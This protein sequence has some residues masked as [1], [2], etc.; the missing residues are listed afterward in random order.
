M[1]PT[2]Q[3]A[4]PGV[5]DWT[6]PITVRGCELAAIIAEAQAQ[7]FNCHRMTVIDMAVYRLMFWKLPTATVNKRVLPARLGTGDQPPFLPVA[8]SKNNSF[9]FPC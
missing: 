8:A 6:Q 3:L 1:K 5:R 9:I 2:A 4:L 7:G